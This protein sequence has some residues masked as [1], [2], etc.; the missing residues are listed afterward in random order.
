MTSP[1]EHNRLQLL[2]NRLHDLELRLAL[3]HE[4]AILE[5]ARD[6]LQQEIRTLAHRMGEEDYWRHGRIAACKVG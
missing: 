3:P 5:V 1:A 4:R 6:A 2:M